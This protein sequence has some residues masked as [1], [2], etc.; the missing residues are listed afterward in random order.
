MKYEV[1]SFEYFRCPLNR[2]TFKVKDIKDWIERQ[3]H[4]RVLNLFAGYTLLDVNEVRVDLDDESPADFHLDA[5][6]YVQQA[7]TY[8]ERFDTIIMDPPYALRKS[9]EMYGGRRV[10]SFMKIKNKI[11]LILNPKGRVITL[12]Y[13]S[14]SM[15]N[16]RGFVA[17]SIALF[18]HGGAIHD[19]IG[20]VEVLKAT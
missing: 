3:C 12:G 6:E 7:N 10:S 11:P 17:E 16:E 4:G 2:Y 14:N 13:H 1:Q 8:D 18:S 9:M 5:F 19:T 20:V 15:G